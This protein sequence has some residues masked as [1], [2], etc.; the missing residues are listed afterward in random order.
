MWNLTG[1]DI[2]RAREELKA[3]RAAFQAQYE[4]E[5]SRLDAELA[6]IERVEQVAT[7]FISNHKK[8]DPSKLATEPASAMRGREPSSSATGEQ[9][10]VEKSNAPEA[11]QAA[12]KSP[13]RWRMNLG[14]E[15]AAS[16]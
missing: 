16:P 3:R 9:A 15:E 6:D 4:T 10:A 2:R 13:S 11:A 7:D 14:A 12:G 5:V 1:D 8:D